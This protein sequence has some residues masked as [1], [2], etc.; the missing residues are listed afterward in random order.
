MQYNRNLYAYLNQINFS[1][2][3][4]CYSL[5]PLWIL[6]RY[7]ELGTRINLF[8][9]ANLYFHQVLTKINRNYAEF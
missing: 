2:I 8:I 9:S 7:G 1:Q 6:N 5:P 3:L 4:C